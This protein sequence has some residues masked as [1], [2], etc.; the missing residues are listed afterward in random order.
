MGKNIIYEKFYKKNVL[1]TYKNFCPI[2][3][4]QFWNEHTNTWS[5]SLD[6]YGKFYSDKVKDISDDEVKKFYGDKT[7]SIEIKYIK[8]QIVEENGKVSL[9]YSYTIRK[10]KVGSQY[11]KVNRFFRYVTYNHSNKNFY[12]GKIDSKNVKTLSKKLR[13]NSFHLPFLTELRLYIRNRINGIIGK[14]H[15]FY[16]NG[17]KNNL[18]DTV[19]TESIKF[20]A[21]EIYKKTNLFFDYNSNFLEGEIFKIYLKIN[22]IAYPDSASQYV[23]LVIPKKILV[24]NQNL[25]TAFMTENNLKGRFLR[26]ILNQ[27]NDINFECIVEV[28]HNFGVDYINKIRE[29]FFSRSSDGMFSAWFNMGGVTKKYE[30][31]NLSNH[32]KKRIID[33]IR[34]DEEITWVLIKDHLSMI[35]GLE[36]FGENFKMKFKSRKEFNDEHYELSELLNSY[37]KGNVTRIYNE[38][39]IKEVELPIMGFGVDYYPKVLT[40]TSEYNEESQTQSNCVK[41]YIDTP[42]SLIVSLRLSDENA[43]ERLTVEY[44]IKRNSLKRIQTRARFNETPSNSWDL[45]LEILDNRIELLYKNNTFE[46]PIYRKEYATGKILETKAVFEDRDS[47]FIPLSPVWE[48]RKGIFEDYIEFDELPF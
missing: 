1:K 41:T 7:K 6:K 44:H 12:H 46:L 15:D 18:G 30:D 39:F 26:K 22:G 40:T 10:R 36:T 27:G 11:F 17:G 21:Q 34:D 13:C 35:K 25:V 8:I 19:A 2:S 37:K 29:S 48:Q 38:E 42:H 5:S 3:G 14:E 31:F 9:K 32:D 45:P 28:Y 23:S 24:K 33:L 47:N 43:K 20:F 4:G 16:L